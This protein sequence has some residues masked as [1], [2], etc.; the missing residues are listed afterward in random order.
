[1]AFRVLIS[2]EAR[3]GLKCLETAAARRIA[4]KLEEAA[5]NPRHFFERL[6]GR[7]EYKLR[8]GDVRVI[9]NIM[10]NDE[11]IFVRSIGHRK[12]VYDRI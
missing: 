5:S 4:E 7:E 3:A 1:M 8:V 6:A 2:D 11:V 9:A 10:Y 12:N